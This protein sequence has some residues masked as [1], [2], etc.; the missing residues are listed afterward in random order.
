MNPRFGQYRIIEWPESVEVFGIYFGSAISPH[1]MVLEEDTDLRD[2]RFSFLI[3][4]NGNFNT[5]HQIFLS[6]RAEYPYLSKAPVVVFSIIP[7][8]PPVY[9]NNTEVFK[10]CIS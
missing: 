10:G 9:I 8:V 7:I 5:R 6:V 2:K 4:C 1:Q 3:L